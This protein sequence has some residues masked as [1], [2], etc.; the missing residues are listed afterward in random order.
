MANQEDPFNIDSAQGSIAEIM[1]ECVGEN[2]DEKSQKWSKM[3]E[4]FKT[5]IKIY[6]RR[7]LTHI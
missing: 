1:N 2:R 6:C 4:A 3:K 7:S 5:G